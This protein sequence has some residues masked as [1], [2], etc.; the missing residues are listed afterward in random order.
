MDEQSLVGIRILPPGLL[1]PVDNIYRQSPA[2]IVRQ[3]NTKR[4]WLVAH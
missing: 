1:R 2:M 4:G 3:T